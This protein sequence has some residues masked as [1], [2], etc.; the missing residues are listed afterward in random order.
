[1]HR[2]THVCTH[3][4]THA[5][6]CTH[7]HPLMHRCKECKHTHTHTCT[8][9]WYTHTFIY[10]HFK[11]IE[12]ILNWSAAVRAV[13]WEWAAYRRFV[14]HRLRHT[15]V[16]RV[17]WDIP[18]YT[19]STASQTCSHL[20]EAEGEPQVCVPPHAPGGVCLSGGWVQELTSHVL[21]LQGLRST[22]EAQG[23]ADVFIGQTSVNI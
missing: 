3:I 20:R 21:H 6:I 13:W 11:K 2:C 23:K 1:M 18:F 5:N 8:H 9:L 7:A 15:P 19:H 22:P 12:I 10:I 16:H 14:L 4:Y 17:L